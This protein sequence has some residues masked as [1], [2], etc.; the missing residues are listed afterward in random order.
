MYENKNV[1][2]ESNFTQKYLCKFL[3]ISPSLLAKVESNERNLDITKLLILY[4][5]FNVSYEYLILAKANI[6]KTLLHS[7]RITNTLNKKLYPNEWIINYLK[8]MKKISNEN[9]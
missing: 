6:I 8:Y 1:T 9:Y 7:E 4:Y 3:E 5:L 2:L